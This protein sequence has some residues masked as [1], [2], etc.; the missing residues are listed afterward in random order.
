MKKSHLLFFGLLL[1]AVALFFGLR[2]YNA[3]LPQ[4]ADESPEFTMQA[5]DLYNAFQDDEVGAG[6]RYNDKLIEVKGEVREVTFNGDGRMSVL[7]ESGAV[8][9]TVVCE[10]PELAQEPA[11]GSQVAIK[12]YCAGFNFDVL[13]QRCAFTE[14]NQTTT[15]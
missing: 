6:K 13:L 10:F 15:N 2:S 9:G 8:F 1:A 11:E 14:F 3:E 12:G 5:E 4:A 7:L